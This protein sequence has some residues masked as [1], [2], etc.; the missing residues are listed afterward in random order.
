MMSPAVILPSPSFSMRST[1][2][3]ESTHLSSTS[4]RLSTMSVTSSTTSGIVVN[5]CSAPSIFTAVMAEPCSDERRMRRRLLP[6]VVPKP[7]SSGSHVNLPYVGV[8]LSESTSSLRGRMRSRQLRAMNV[9][10]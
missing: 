9:F 3:F 5:S 10:V 7:R 2:A 6:I 4:L 8:M 1:R